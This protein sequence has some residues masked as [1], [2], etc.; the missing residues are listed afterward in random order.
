MNLKDKIG[1]RLM[2]TFYGPELTPAVAEFLTTTR[3]GGVILFGHNIESLGQVAQLNRALQDLAARNGLPPLLIG[4]DEEGGR[5]SRMPADGQKWIAPSQ[6]AQSAAG[7]GA[8]G[9]C[10][11]VTARQLRRLGFNLD[12]APIADVNNNP[13]NPVIATRSFGSDPKLVSQAVTEAIQTYI[14]EGLA[15][16]VKHFPGHGDTSVDSHLGLPIVHRSMARLEAIE[17]APFRAAFEAGVPALMTAHILYP[18]IEPEDRPATLSRYFLQTLL[19]QQM[20]FEGVVFSDALV[21]EAIASRYSVPEACF[22]TIEAGAD[23][24]M[25]LGSFGMQRQCIERLTEQAERLE[26]DAPL[27][28]IAAFK[29]R[30][31]QPPLEADSQAENADA[32]II[33]S[34]TQRSI[35]VVGATAALPL[36]AE[37]LPVV[38]DFELPI[39]SIV[40]EERQPGKLLAELLTA[41][42]PNL[43]YLAVPAASPQEQ[44][45]ACLQAATRASRLLIVTRNATRLP[46]QAH[47][48]KALLEV[49]PKTVVIAARDPYD[50]TL[51]QNAALRLATYGDPPASIRALVGALFGEF[52]PSGQLPVMLA[53]D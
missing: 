47:L 6:M 18:E 17:L 28:R 35:T 37:V 45:E 11:G 46:E 22:L 8:P 43:H 9:M 41:R 26:W 52:R 10:A 20:G 48:L 15:P 30:Y 16:C 44:T 53:E 38:I 19:R 4:I 13:A 23:V 33:T 32:E 49:Q 34:A 27:A 12:F 31:C 14:A 36:E 40:E 1:Q 25:P 3:A 21:M 29:A 50:L 5:V 7:S 42:W 24:A 51:A 2:V 39:A